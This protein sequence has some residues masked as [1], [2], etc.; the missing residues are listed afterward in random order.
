MRAPRSLPGFRGRTGR[1]AYLGTLC[2]A[3]AVMVAFALSVRAAGPVPPPWNVGVAVAGLVLNFGML[4]LLICL[5]ARRLRDAGRSP[6]WGL[7]PL[8]IGIAGIALSGTVDDPA[9]SLATSLANMAFV[10][11][12]CLM[13]PRPVPEA[14]DAQA[15]ADALTA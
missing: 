3:C 15:P 11:T 1:L 13:P 6:W 9:R 12:L 2:A 7:V 14:R 4:W 8:A 10:A 5:N